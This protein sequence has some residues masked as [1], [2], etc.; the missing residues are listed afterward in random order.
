MDGALPDRQRAGRRGERRADGDGGIGARARR[1]R[2]RKSRWSAGARLR[3]C[4]RARAPTRSPR[5]ARRAKACS[6][7]RPR[8][9][10]SRTGSCGAGCRGPSARAS[11]SRASASARRGR[12]SSCSAATSSARG[13]SARTT[14]SSTG[15]SA[16]G[17]LVFAKLLVHALLQRATHAADAE[18]RRLALA[19]GG[20]RPRRALL[21]VPRVR[22]APPERLRVVAALPHVRAVS[23]ARSRRGPPRRRDRRAAAGEL[24]AP[25]P[26]VRRAGRARY[27]NT[28]QIAPL[29]QVPDV[30]AVAI[31]LRDPGTRR[32]WHTTDPVGG[33]QHGIAGRGASRERRWS[34]ARAAGVHPLAVRK[35]ISGGAPQSTNRPRARWSALR[36][37]GQRHRQGR[38]ERRW[39]SPPCRTVTSVEKKYVI[40]EEELRRDRRQRS[41]HARR[42]LE[43]TGSRFRQPGEAQL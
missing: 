36:E 20:T 28:T 38:D 32:A 16:A 4:S 23:R 2:S 41:A 40:D 42:D 31:N 30:T 18:E 15:G 11:C 5:A 10:R 35:D 19:S 14:W 21:P 24:R 39:R 3:G 37:D 29:L 6:R 27:T 12:C 8:S 33:L 9:R 7:S 25:P 22:R 43:G 1:R 34:L 13:T 26:R 17:T